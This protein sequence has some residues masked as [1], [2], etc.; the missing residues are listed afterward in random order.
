MKLLRKGRNPQIECP[1]CGSL[2]EIEEGDVRRDKDG[3]FATCEICGSRL[4]INDEPVI[5][6][7][8][9]RFPE[10]FEYT[11]DA[12][13][14]SNETVERWIGEAV[15]QLRRKPDLP[16]YTVSSGDTSVMVENFPDDEEYCVTVVKNPYMCSIA[17]QDEDRK[18]QKLA[19]D[20]RTGTWVEVEDS[21]SIRGFCSAC[22]WKAHLYEDDV[23]G[24]NY[25]PQCGVK[26]T[27][28]IWEE[29]FTEQRTGDEKNTCFICKE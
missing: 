10:D 17:Y 1:Y 2:F 16:Y 29:E 7:E 8:N 24:M 12:V 9:V 23:L 22:G 14:I 3:L 26:M 19:T 4:P 11:G 15:G 6:P 13:K 25:C 21:N 28:V 20:K 18:A 5:T 27:G